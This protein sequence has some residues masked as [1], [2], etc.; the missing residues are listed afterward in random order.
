MSLSPRQASLPGVRLKVRSKQAH[1]PLR[2]PVLRPSGRCL[3]TDY[4]FEGASAR[5]FPLTG[6]V[7]VHDD[8]AKRRPWFLYRGSRWWNSV[9]ADFYAAGKVSDYCAAWRD[10]KAGKGG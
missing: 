6:F 5:D 10:E 8:E 4:G 7:E 1:D 9:S 3:L 2:H